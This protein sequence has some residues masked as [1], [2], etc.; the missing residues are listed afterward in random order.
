[1]KKI[2]DIFYDEIVKEAANG[3]IDCGFIMPICFGTKELKNNEIVDV[4]IAKDF[5]NTMIPT[6]LIKDRNKLSESINKYVSLAKTFYRD[7]PRLDDTTD[8]EKYIIS[9]LLVNTLVT[10]FSD[11]SNLF[12]RYS[13]FLND[14][15]LDSFIE[16]KN[17]GYSSILKSNIMVSL[18]KQSIV[19]ETPNAFSISLVDNDENILYKFPDIRFGIS[20]DKA[21]IYAVQTKDNNENK[22]I[23]RILRKT[24]EGFDEKNTERDPVSNPENLYSVSPWALVA[25]S[26]AIPIIKN[27][28]GATEFLVPY[29]LVNR[30]NSLEISYSLLKEKYKDQ[31][32][33]PFVE[34]LL[35]KKEVQIS[36]HED[37]QRNVTD[38]FIRNFRRLD[39]HFSNINIDSFQLEM[40]SCLHFKVED[41]YICNNSLLNEV[42]SIADIY[43]EK[44]IGNRNK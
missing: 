19:E 32:N 26:I 28:T 11:I 38:K 5:E 4:A 3:A 23:E 39:H 37:T 25:L 24:G 9:K 20:K 42:Y 31:T 21:Y 27:Y 17:I 18:E 33:T 1:M 14:K 16:P 10:D 2:E 30:W 12:D 43:N 44:N 29:F 40:D 36:T 22:K 15:S 6:L 8:K 34:Q 13:D 7:D 41:N 35:N